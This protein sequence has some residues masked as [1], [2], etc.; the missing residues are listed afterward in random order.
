VAGCIRKSPRR[1]QHHVQ[2]TEN[3][4]N[5]PSL[6]WFIFYNNEVRKRIPFSNLSKAPRAT[7]ILLLIASVDDDGS[8][9]AL[10]RSI[11]KSSKALG[12]TD[13]TVRP[14]KKTYLIPQITAF[15]NAPSCIYIP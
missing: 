6:N 9:T 2:D 10:R 1:W 15:E 4:K 12:N 14:K 7:L 8:S 13:I 11:S 3:M 5:A